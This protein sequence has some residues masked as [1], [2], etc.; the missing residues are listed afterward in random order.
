M[1]SWRNIF[2]SL[3]IFAFNTLHAQQDEIDFYIQNFD[4]TADNEVLL[5]QYTLNAGAVCSDLAIEKSNDRNVFEEVFK[6]FGVCGSSFRD[7]TYHWIDEK[8]SQGR[9]YYRLNLYGYIFSDTLIIDFTKL[10]KEGVLAYPNPAKDFIHLKFENSRKEIFQLSIF[11]L[12]GNQK[13]VQS[14]STDFITIPFEDWSNGTYFYRLEN[15]N[16][17]YEGRFV[18]IK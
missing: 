9:S 6:H 3:L 12:A 14:L 2:I 8:P 13:L 4:V 18:I 16:F 1:N 5:F 11:D 15:I 7:E 10:G 17:Q